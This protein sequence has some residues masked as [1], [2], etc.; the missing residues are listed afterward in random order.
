MNEKTTRTL[1]TVVVVLALIAIAAWLIS[2]FRKRRNG[3]TTVVERNTTTQN[4]YPYYVP[5]ITPPKP[6]TCPVNTSTR[7]C[8]VKPSSGCVTSYSTPDGKT[9]TLD[10]AQSTSDCCCYVTTSPAPVPPAIINSNA[11]QTRSFA[12]RR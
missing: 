9:W 7:Q 2:Y 3:S 6:K 12:Q 1:W 4:Y 8:N 11:F 5:V 10:N